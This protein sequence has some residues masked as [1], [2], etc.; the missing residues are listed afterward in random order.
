MAFRQAA[1]TIEI[2]R[3]IVAVR[4]LCAVAAE[5]RVADADLLAGTAVT[6]ADLADPDGEVSDGDE[7]TIARTLLQMVPDS[8]GIGVS[9]GSRVNLTNLG[10]FGFA[11]MASGTLRELLSIG[12]RFF[13]L[14][15]LHVSIRLHEGPEGCEIAID[16]NH[17]PDDV[18]RFFTERDIAAIVATVPSFVH[19][20]LARH[21]DEVEVELAI[22]Q[23]YLRPLLRTVQLNHI[24]FDC[25]HNVIRLPRGMLDE[26]L[27]Q[28]DEHTLAIC[29]DQCEQILQ[30]RS[31]R[32]GMAAAVRA[33][34]LSTPGEMPGLDDVADRLGMHPRTVRRR[35]A[36]E[37]ATFRALTNEVRAALAVE[38]LSQVGLTVQ[39]AARHLGYSETAAFTH[40]FSR[41]FGVPPTEYR[42]RRAGR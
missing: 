42:Q 41:W 31:A 19:S 25:A 38:L 21:A 33:Q 1:P 10:M 22:G 40:A 29:M 20:V 7:I 27:P 30:R 26:P 11:A 39:E 18:R 12:L 15:T 24:E 28:A 13:S 37:G 23:E 8:D 6:P 17:L 14:S 3:P 32:R 36:A 9:V 4:H 16:A 34:L 2:R 5:H 35:L